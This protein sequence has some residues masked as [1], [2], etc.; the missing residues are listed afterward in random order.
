MGL[1]VTRS[2][3][4]VHDKF[5]SVQTGFGAVEA[6]WGIRAVKGGLNKRN[7]N[8]ENCKRLAQ[9]CVKHVCAACILVA[10][11]PFASVSSTSAH[12]R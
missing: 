1:R 4:I 10:R 12:D 2:I 7:A 5:L 8:A 6:K 9:A 3:R 11:L